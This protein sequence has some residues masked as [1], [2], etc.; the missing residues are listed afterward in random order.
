MMR[1]LPF[2]AVMLALIACVV[3][4]AATRQESQIV[5]TGIVTT[6]DVIVSSE[7]QGR[8][9]QLKVKEG[10]TVK[11]GELLGLIQPDQWKADVAYYAD[12]ER[13]LAAQDST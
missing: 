8:L 6:D 2:I 3:Y 11:R 9:Q 10:D 1:R 7:V 4:Y 5:L 13:Q 12:S